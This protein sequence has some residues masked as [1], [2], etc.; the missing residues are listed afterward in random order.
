M[1]GADL[2]RQY[3]C[4]VQH[5]LTRQHG[6]STGNAQLVLSTQDSSLTSSST[7]HAVL[8]SVARL[9]AWDS[10]AA[11]IVV[12]C[13]LRP[14]PVAGRWLLERP[15][16]GGNS[17]PNALTV[18]QAASLMG[19]HYINLQQQQQHFGVNQSLYSKKGAT[20]YLVG[21][22]FL[23][24]EAPRRALA[25][26][27]VF[28]ASDARGQQRT[29]CDTRVIIR[30]PLELQVRVSSGELDNGEPSNWWP[31]QLRARRNT[32]AP[33]RSIE[34]RGAGVLRAPHIVRMGDSLRVECRGAGAPI[35]SVRWL[36]NGALLT[37]NAAADLQLEVSDE[38][39]D[40][41]QQQAA[42]GGFNATTRQH[43]TSMLL[44]S[45]TMRQ[46]QPRDVGL[47]MF[48][49]HAGNALG[50][51]ARAQRAVFVA[52]RNELEVARATPA[53]CDIATPATDA[54]STMHDGEF[55]LAVFR[56]ANP[57]RRAVLL[58]HEPAELRCPVPANTQVEW[59][60]F[61]KQQQQQHSN[62]TTTRY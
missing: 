18:E 55:A 2:R 7:Q 12:P 50:E 29:M 41:E 53:A 8:H 56:R 47:L 51:R 19:A 27:Y 14:P 9:V 4:R 38:W 30:Q 49:C 3:G 11:S 48:E 25:G 42:P 44:S 20:K 40:L 57:W 45:I 58:E 39:L 43:A 23:A 35:D 5:T 16:G 28:V 61:G 37:A 52:E 13:A 22:S 36:R 59:R 33:E 54:D 10:N 60:E 6:A 24:I 62:A 21:P 17:S 26:R 46:V 32:V 15:S 1:D 31:Q 34:A